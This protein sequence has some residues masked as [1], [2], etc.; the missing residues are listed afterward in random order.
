[1]KNLSSISSFIPDN[2]IDKIIQGEKLKKLTN[3]K[4]SNN[5][6][7]KYNSANKSFINEKI[8]CII[9]I[10]NFN[11]KEKQKLQIQINKADTIKHLANLIQIEVDKFYNIKGHAFLYYKG[12]KIKENEIINNLLIN[13]DDIININLT[14]GNE[15][16]ENKKKENKEINFD[17]IFVQLEEEE[18]IIK[19]KL[20]NA[21]KE[22]GDLKNIQE[23]NLTKKIISYLFPKCNNH[24]EEKLNYICLT[25]Y[26]SFCE[27]GYEEHKIQ[28]PE[29]EIISKNKLID[30]NFEVKNIKQTLINKYDELVFN[31]DVEKMDKNQ[32]NYISTNDLFSKIKIEINDIHERMDILFNSV[33]EKYQKINLKFL[34]TYEEKMPQII[35]FSEYI[36]KTLTSFDNLNIFSNENMFI[37]IYDNYLNIKNITDKYYNNII[38]LKEIIIKYKEFLESFKKKGNNLFD[39]VKQGIDNII[40]VKN[41]EKIFNS[42]SKELFQSNITEY[43]MYKN[44][45]MNSK[46]LKKNFNDISL[47]TTKDLNQSINLRFLFSDKKP[48][49]SVTFRQENNNNNIFKKGISSS[50]RQK[51]KTIN[52]LSKNNLLE[53][54]NIINLNLENKRINNDSQ[55]IV[56]QKRY[57]F[58]SSNISLNSDLNIPNKFSSNLSSLAESKINIYSLIYGTNKIIRFISK[59]KKL[60]VISP[61]LSDLAIIKFETYISKLNFKN[62]FY[63]SGG[64]N[65]PKAF[66]E[67]DSNSNKFNQLTNMPTNHY[68][69]NMVGY[70]NYIYSI[71]G[72]KSKKVEKYN[73]IEN[74]W[75]SL[76]DLE[77]ER[78]YPNSLIFNDNLFIFG[79]INNTKDE[80]SKDINIIEYINLKDYIPD[81]NKRWTKIELKSNFPF[82]SGI[83]KLDNTNILVGGKL[84]INENCI[85]LSYSMQIENINNNYEINIKLN[86][87]KLKEPDE[88]GGNNFYAL[89]E[90]GEIFGNFSLVNPYLFYIFDKN[91]NKFTN[92]E[93]SEQKDDI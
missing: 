68:Y 78:T 41:S 15:N 28:F 83:I 5:L 21:K 31:I 52:E 69:H 70:K 38:S 7:K 62:K 36:D 10:I 12:I 35:E 60:E 29:H 82:N 43:N 50:F 87:I 88:F 80:L 58:G 24:K 73:L 17:V 16:N 66:S 8:I 42:S 91:I 27:H 2:S 40:K 32:I 14:D 53:N 61:D 6:L 37:E 56:K 25:C 4:D 92:L 81:D 34:T 9:S 23:Y 89:D 76:P 55:E 54:E 33:R 84:D 63:I 51:N 86:D 48:K 67:Y 85:N 93:Y 72:F 22:N 1:M 90:I 26:N 39:Y 77:F 18:L 71:S 44:S 30:L 46:N 45:N 19:E 57:N 3:K 49:K 59:L 79:K 64:Y 47:N 65:T 75:I 13:Q 11:N 20:S 74:Q